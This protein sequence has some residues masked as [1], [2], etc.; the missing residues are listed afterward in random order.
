MALAR[1]TIAHRCSVR[2]CTAALRMSCAP[3]WSDG[4]RTRT[5][6]VRTRATHHGSVL[7]NTTG[8]FDPL[9]EGVRRLCLPIPTTRGR[10]SRPEQRRGEIPAA[11]VHALHRVH[12]AAPRTEPVLLRDQLDTPPLSLPAVVRLS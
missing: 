6:A 3:P 9:R 7:S 2:R 5:S 1:R 12:V 4:V 8:L 10:R 11:G